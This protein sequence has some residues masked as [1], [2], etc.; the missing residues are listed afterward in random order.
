MPVSLEST[1]TAAQLEKLADFSLLLSG[2]GEIL[3]VEVS[4]EELSDSFLSDWV[5]QNWIDTVT[6]DSRE[7]LAALLAAAASGSDE[8]PRQ[9]LVQVLEDG[10]ELP[11]EYRLL[12]LDDGARLLALGRDMRPVASLRQQLVNAQQTLEQDY[13]RLRQVETRY[14]RMFEMVGEAV[15][16]VDGASQ[17]VLEA[18]PVAG[19][20][21]A[22]GQ[23]VVGR[24]FPLGFDER[25]TAVLGK[26]LDE[27]RATGKGSVAGVRAEDGETLLAVSVAYLRQ[28]GETRFLV[29]VA[30]S[31]AN[32]SSLAPGAGQTLPPSLQYAPDAVL[33]TDMDGKVLGA[34]RA[35]LEL[36]QLLG[37]EQAMGHSADRWLGRSGVDFKVLLTNLRQREAVR[38]FSSTLRGESGT[39]AEV[40]ISACR[41][42]DCE[43]PAL[44]FFVR[45]I[46]RR[47]HSDHPM[48]RQLPRSIEQVTQRIGRIPL[49]ELVRE[50]KDVIEALCVEEALKLTHDNRASAAELLGL[51]RQ[52]LYAK[53]RRYGIGG[54]DSG[55]ARQQ[56][57]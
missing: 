35:F 4:A 45:D 41:I 36:A 25:G 10:T 40:E 7:R 32:E 19:D 9:D 44:I 24:P 48:T 12:Q 46:G 5:G 21:L 3:K 17:R 37:E 42:E 11:V 6:D 49:K 14:R 57:D 26:L 1:A 28:A 39:L 50:S 20:L 15:L 51:S 13:W 16:V 27:A 31:A 53:L 30:P 38:L 47:V 54:S 2:D 23:S 33:L 55:A 34:N 56:E 52:S 29:R 18:N 22:G 8:V 43:P